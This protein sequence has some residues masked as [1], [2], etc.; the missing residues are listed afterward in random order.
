MSAFDTQTTKE[1]GFRRQREPKIKLAKFKH[2]EYDICFVL[3]CL[4]LQCG[5][6]CF[7]KIKSDWKGI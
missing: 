5:F 2:E 7:S 1:N 4:D 6:R 3:F